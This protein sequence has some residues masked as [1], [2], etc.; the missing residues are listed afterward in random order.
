MAARKQEEILWAHLTA[1]ELHYIRQSGNYHAVDAGRM[2]FRKGDQPDGI[3]IL[4]SGEMDIFD[5][6]RQGKHVHL[7]TLAPGAVLGEIGSLTRWPRTASAVAKT[8]SIVFQINEKFIQGLISYR[9]GVATQ[10]LLNV[11]TIMAS[12]IVRLTDEVSRLK[13]PK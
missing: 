1:D 3:Y 8:N 4:M 7:T 13:S 9:P 2:L 10:F 12:T 6:D 11:L 5:T